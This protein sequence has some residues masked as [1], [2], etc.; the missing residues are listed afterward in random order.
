MPGEDRKIF[1]QVVGQYGGP[2][3][4]RRAHEVQLAFDTLVEACRRQREEWLAF[5][6]V[7]LGTLAA[8]AGSAM[9]LEALL[10]N[11]QQ[12]ETLEALRHDLQPRLR[13]PAASDRQRPDSLARPRGASRRYRAFQR[14]LARF[15]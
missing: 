8:L 1:Q 15:H 13:S 2:A 4:A 5:V 6:R 11:A 14:P 7:P 3:F 12:L 9:T 10:G